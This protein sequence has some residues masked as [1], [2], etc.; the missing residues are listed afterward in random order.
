MGAII[1]LIILILA[2]LQAVRV[3]RSVVA[4]TRHA[5]RSTRSWLRGIARAVVEDYR[6]F[7]ARRT[8]ARDA[9]HRRL[10]R[11]KVETAGTLAEVIRDLQLE[12]ATLRG[13]QQRYSAP[14]MPAPRVAPIV[15]YRD[16]ASRAM[17]MPALTSSAD[18]EDAEERERLA[19]DRLIAAALERQGIAVS[20]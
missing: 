6:G 8:R 7:R 3:A 17:S 13:A 5:S 19:E 2:T 14:A 11:V 16:D 15:V 12:L 10:E 9:K 18:I 20:S 1:Y 4:G